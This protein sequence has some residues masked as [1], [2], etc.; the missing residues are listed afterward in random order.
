MSIILS[1]SRYYENRMPKHAKP[2][3]EWILDDI[4]KFTRD[5]YLNKLWA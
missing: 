2:N 1:L 5:K 3:P 4:I